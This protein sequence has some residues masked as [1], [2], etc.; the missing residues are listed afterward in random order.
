MNILREEFGIV[1]NLPIN[2]KVKASNSKV[3]KTN[4]VQ[5]SNSINESE[6]KVEESES[7][8]SKEDVVMSNENSEE[9][10]DN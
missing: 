2:A 4:T 5:T 1:R 7:L 9:T 10:G 6:I 3:I 8:N